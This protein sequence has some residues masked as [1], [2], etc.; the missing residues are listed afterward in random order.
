[1]PKKIVNE[2]ILEFIKELRNK[3][4]G[5]KRIQ[6]EIEKMY[7]WSPSLS[8]IRYWIREILED[9]RVFSA[10]IPW[11]PRKRSELAYIIGVALGDASLGLAK[12]TDRPKGKRYVFKLKVRDKEF[13]EEV[14]KAIERIGLHCSGVKEYYDEREE[15]MYYIVQC[16]V[17]RFVMFL[18]SLKK[19]PEKVW[20]WIEGYEREF[21]KG[22]YESEGSLLEK[23]QILI[24]NSR[25]EF[26]DIVAECLQRLRIKYSI[27]YHECVREWIVYIPVREVPRFLTAIKP[28]IKYSRDDPHYRRVKKERKKRMN[29]N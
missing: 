7:G 28:A 22:F 29:E 13:A 24:Y 27:S 8:T 11:R 15:R 12:R 1:M 19:Y 16:H 20:K 10:E 17:K 23:E 9:R 4:Y 25:K 21:L 6:R 14:R 18:R 5:Y 26:I 2:E 3:G